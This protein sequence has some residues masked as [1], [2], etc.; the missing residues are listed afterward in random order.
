M[1]TQ[2][3][4]NLPAMQETLV[5][6]PGWEDLLERYTLPTLVSLGFPWGSACKEFSCSVGV[7][8]RKKVKSLSHVRLFVTLWTVACQA[9]LSM[10]LFRPGYWSR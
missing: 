10:G 8:E 6:L 5:R 4:N 7:K 9:P 2:T 3:I 1:V